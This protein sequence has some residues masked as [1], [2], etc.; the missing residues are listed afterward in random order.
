ME[1][2]NGGFGFLRSPK[3]NYLSGQGDIYG[4]YRIYTSFRIRTQI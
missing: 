4:L 1:I 2:L 3:N